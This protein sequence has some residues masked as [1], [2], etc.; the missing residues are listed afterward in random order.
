MTYTQKLRLIA[1]GTIAAISIIEIVALCV[2]VQAGIDK[3]FTVTSITGTVVVFNASVWWFRHRY[4]SARIYY[5]RKDE[6]CAC[7][8]EESKRPE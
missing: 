1:A 3:L 7:Y 6:E 8:P 4:D 5:A 2:L